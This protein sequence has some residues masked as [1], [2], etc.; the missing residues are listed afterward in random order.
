MYGAGIRTAPPLAA[1][2]AACTFA[3]A[4][5]TRGWSTPRRTGLLVAAGLATAAIG[6]WT[7]AIMLPTNNAL[8]G[9]LERLEEQVK[10]KGSENGVGVGRSEEVDG[11]L[12]RWS[13][14]NWCRS[15]L[16]IVG[17]L[18]AVEAM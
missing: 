6:P 4:F 11:L 9:R 2:S 5:L 14:L 7:F 12:K 8:F 13:L 10:E 18:L 1:L 17:C 3:A 15:A 16:P